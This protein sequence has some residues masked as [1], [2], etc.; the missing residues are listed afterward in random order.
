MASAAPATAPGG[1]MECTRIGHHLPE[2][3]DE[4]LPGQHQAYCG[5][6]LHAR[7]MFL[8]VLDPQGRTLLHRDIPA[9]PDAFLEAIAPHRDGLVVAC[10]C[11]FSWYWL[12]DT[13]PSTASPSSSATPGDAGHP[14]DQDQERP[15][16]LR[17]DRPPAP[18][19]PAAAVVCLSDRDAGHPRP[20]PTPVLPRPAAVRGLDARP[21]DQLAIPARRA[22][23]Q[24]PLPDNRAGVLDRVDD[25]C[26]RRTLEVDL[27]LAGHLD[28]QIAELEAFLATQAKGHDLPNFYRLRSIPGWE[29]C[30]R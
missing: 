5:V 23:G 20:A 7:T 30:W 2:H 6:D 1:R 24:A 10:E 14:R 17:E 9:N 18:R 28:R 12:A 26:V 29:R 21:I 16:R 8:C 19:R 27:E 11:T 13:C 22:D 4:T 15:G 3:H 25:E